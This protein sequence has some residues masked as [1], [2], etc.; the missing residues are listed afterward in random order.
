MLSI[1]IGSTVLIALVVYLSWRYE[2]SLEKTTVI[3][4]LRGFI[5]LILLGYAL[6]YI[7]ALEHPAWIILVILFMT[8]FATHAARQRANKRLGSYKTAFL[9]ILISSGLTLSLMYFL[10]IIPF[11]IEKAIPVAGMAIGKTMNT[12]ALMVDR[13]E[14]EVQKSIDII[15]GKIALGANL[16]QA[17]QS[18]EKASIRMSM[19]PVINNMATA[20]VVFIPGMATGMLLA[21]ASPVYA[22]SFQIAIFCMI[23]SVSIL[24]GIIGTTLFRSTVMSAAMLRPADENS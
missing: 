5:Q 2:L 16:K 6:K 24:T 19:I 14:G 12:Y 8:T 9:T 3:S 21:G 7:F 13:L 15:E 18:V 23:I 11:E 20:G 22:V 1:Y 10:R 4:T 17:L